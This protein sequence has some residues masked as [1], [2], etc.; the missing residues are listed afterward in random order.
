VNAPPPVAM[1]AG[2]PVIGQPNDARQTLPSQGA[3]HGPYKPYQRPGSAEGHSLSGPSA[4]PGGPADFYRQ[5]A[6]Y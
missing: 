2:Y 6:A 4:P 5:S 3:N 1:N